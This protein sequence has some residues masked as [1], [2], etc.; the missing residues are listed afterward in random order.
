MMISELQ[1]ESEEIFLEFG[2][3]KKLLDC[4][5]KMNKSFGTIMYAFGG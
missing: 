4:K 5:N 3:A 2:L 1:L